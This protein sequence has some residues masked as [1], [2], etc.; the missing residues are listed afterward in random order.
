MPAKS[1]AVDDFGHRSIAHIL[2]VDPAGQHPPFVDLRKFRLEPGF[3]LVG[4]LLRHVL[5]AHDHDRR[6]KVDAADQALHERSVQARYGGVVARA[7]QLAPR[8]GE[9]GVQIVP[10][11]LLGLEILLSGL[12]RIL[13]VA[14]LAEQE[15]LDS[16]R[17]YPSLLERMG[18]FVGQQPPAGGG[19]RAVL[20]LVKDEVPAD[21][22]SAGADSF[23]RTRRRAAGMDPHA[24]EIAAETGLHKVAGRTVKRLA[25]LLQ[26]SVNA[27]RCNLW[28]QGAC[29]GAGVGGHLALEIL[30]LTPA[31][32]THT[33][34]SQR[35]A[36]GAR[37][38]RC[39]LIRSTARPASASPV[40]PP[41]QL[42]ART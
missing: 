22:I 19:L 20:A 21:G 6:D 35:P 39:A 16:R 42:P 37:L 11:G 26:R 18:Q 9:E 7:G 17:R 31:L 10:E 13:L 34:G 36:A 30:L 14:F 23:G 15:R 3:A 4:I 8:V 32:V 2:V 29:S 28:F 1:R 12:G 41:A 24:A 27:G 5:L 40:R 38:A 25:R 33:V